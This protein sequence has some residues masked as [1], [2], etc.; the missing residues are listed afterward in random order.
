MELTE[1]I[2]EA[3][4]VGAGGAGFPSHIKLAAK[5]EYIIVNGAECEPL[6]RVD[7]QIGALYAKELLTALSFLAKEMGAEHA[8]YALK[9][10]YHEAVSALSSEIKNFPSVSL[11]LLPNIY[12]AGDEQVLVYEVTGR[13]VPEGGIPLA[14]KCVVINTETLLNIYGAIFKGE[15]VTEKYITVTGAVK[16]PATV[17]V[18]LGVSFTEV[19]SLCGG[20]SVRD[21]AVIDGGPMMG[22]LVEAESSVVTKTTKGII[23][24]PS[25]HPLISSKAKKMDAMMKLAKS[26]C[27][28]CML[29]T[30]VCPR[31]LLGHTLHP[32]K[33]MRIASYGDVCDNSADI[34]EAFLCCECGLCEQACIMGLQPWKLNKEL[35]SKLAAKGIKNPRHE[36]PASAHPFREYRKFPIPKLTRML[37]LAAY[38]R[39]APYDEKLTAKPIFV[40]LLLKQSAGAPS[41]PVISEG[42]TVSAGDIIAEIQENSLGSTLHASVSGTVESITD[43]AIRIKLQEVCK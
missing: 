41:K 25:D 9:Q 18:P 40:T 34:T 27:C 23:V 6:L 16:N 20:A 14:V 13:I 4:I 17:K 42:D 31:A 15:P 1:K 29:C 33:I 21:F 26:A 19:I 11:H 30:E 10:K 8:V 24:L 37:G 28:H 39:D 22:K 7:R 2:K 38:D 5:P 32:D 35:K 43:M 36:A 3:G 12:P